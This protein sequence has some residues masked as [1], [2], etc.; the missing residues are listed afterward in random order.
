MKTSHSERVVSCWY[1]GAE[2]P[3]PAAT[4]DHLSSCEGER[5]NRLRRPAKVKG[6]GWSDEEVLEKESTSQC[7]READS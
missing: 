4:V 6:F 5:L 2:A 7:G 1:C 3:Y